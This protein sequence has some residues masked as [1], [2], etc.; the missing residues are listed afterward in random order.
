MSRFLGKGLRYVDLKLAVDDDTYAALRLL[1]RLGLLRAEPVRVAGTD[2]AP[3]DVLLRLLPRPTDLVGRIT[4]AAMIAVEVAGT[5]DGERATHRLWTGL[6]HEEAARR[7]GATATG[8][9][10][11][12]GAAIFA[13]QFARGL[14][15]NGVIS[16]ECLDPAESLRLMEEFGLRVGHEVH[17]GGMAEGPQTPERK[18]G[19]P[20]NAPTPPPP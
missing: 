13:I 14:I 7:Y 19:G 8:Y 9:L 11:G 3:R 4:G 5:K 6:T 16:A 20:L 1:D 12:T 10:V 17:K 15:P 18:G 2:V